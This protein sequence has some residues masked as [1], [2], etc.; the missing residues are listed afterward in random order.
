[1]FSQPS[2]ANRARLHPLQTEDCVS[3][4]QV[5]LDYYKERESDQWRRYEWP[6]ADTRAA[7]RHGTSLHLARLGETRMPAAWAL[8]TDGRT[9]PLGMIATTHYDPRAR[10]ALL[11]TFIAPD[12][13]GQGLQ[14]QA[15][16][17]LFQILSHH[18]DSYLC[19]VASDNV[20]S[21]K[22]M[23][24]CARIAQVDDLSLHEASADIQDEWVRL[25][26][27]AHLFRLTPLHKWPAGALGLRDSRNL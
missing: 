10:C 17:L 20:A 19:F 3:L 21:L 5:V 24:K 22:G 4:A 11:G 25:G 1:M 23:A 12:V 13:R 8:V 14:L 7:M 9:T 26:Q 16:S 18:V 6:F 27:P 15:K 2:D